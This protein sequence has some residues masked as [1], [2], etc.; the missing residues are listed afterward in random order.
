MLAAKRVSVPLSSTTGQGRTLVNDPYAVHLQVAQADNNLIVN[1]DR[2][3]APIQAAL[4]GVLT[5][6]ESG[7]SKEVKLGFAELR[8]G[9]AMYPHAGKEVQFRL[10]LFFKD[11]RSFIESAVFRGTP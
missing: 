5:V 3:A 8:N 2:E 6:S 4:H 9:T 7:N 11:N 10:E 1:W